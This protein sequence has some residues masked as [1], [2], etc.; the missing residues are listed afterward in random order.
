MNTERHDGAH[1]LNLHKPVAGYVLVEGEDENVLMESWNVLNGLLNACGLGTQRE[2]SERVL[3]EY[4]DD[5]VNEN[6]SEPAFAWKE[7]GKEFRNPLPPVHPTEIRTSISSS[8]AVELNTT[9]ALANYTTE[10]ALG[11]KKKKIYLGTHPIA[12]LSAFKH[13]TTAP[14]ININ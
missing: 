8:S 10:V 9:S 11:H 1:I 12:R 7:S 14:S 13:N 4:G 6:G 5:K 2:N 3:G